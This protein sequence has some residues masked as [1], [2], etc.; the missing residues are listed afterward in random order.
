MVVAEHFVE[1][2]EPQTMWAIVG[3]FIARLIGDCYLVS[4]PLATWACLA[5]V[6]SGSMSGGVVERK[7]SG[8][9]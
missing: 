6:S 1:H 3:P 7:E 5:S 4:V 2:G 8:T 9:T